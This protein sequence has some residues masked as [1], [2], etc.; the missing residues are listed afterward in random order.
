ME[1]LNQV[2]VTI[3]KAFEDQLNTNQPITKDSSIIS[4]GYFD[5]TEFNIGDIVLLAVLVGEPINDG[6]CVELPYKPICLNERHL[7]LFELDERHSM[8]AAA[9]EPPYIKYK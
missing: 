7:H 8:F 4:L 6:G 1:K 2:D 9:G 5:G 3:I